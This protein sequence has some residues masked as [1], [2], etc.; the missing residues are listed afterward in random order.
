MGDSMCRVLVDASH[1]FS[2]ERA[3]AETVAEI[4]R[5]TEQAKRRGRPA[6]TTGIPRTGDRARERLAH[7]VRR[8]QETSARLLHEIELREQMELSRESK[9]RR[10]RI[11]LIGQAVLAQM[12]VDPAFDAAITGLLDDHY[13][14]DKPRQLLD[15]PRLTPEEK[16]ARKA[17]P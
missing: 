1:A 14:H 6:G 10:T 8:S 15:L 16:R 7:R 3:F 4:T 2:S 11:F 13:P 12:E 5:L 9:A 17:K